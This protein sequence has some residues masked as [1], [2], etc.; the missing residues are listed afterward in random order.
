VNAA[1]ALEWHVLTGEYPPQEG[2]VA[3]YTRLVARGLADAGDRV[4]VWAPPASGSA[5]ADRGI[6][7]RRLPDCYGR[8]ALAELSGALDRAAAPHR[9]LVQYVPHAFGWRAGNLRFCAWLRSRRRDHVWV[10]FHEVAYP[11]E[12]RAGLRRH[13]LAVVN[14]VMASLV[15]GAAERAFISI[16]AWQ[17]GVDAVTRAGTPIAWLPVPSPI[18]VAGSRRDAAGLAATFGQGHPL[19]GHFGTYGGLIKPLLEPAI[20]ALAGRTDCRILL[21]GRGSGEACRS[22]VEAHP[23]LAERVRATGA[24]E[25]QD[26]SRHVSACTVMMQ[27][28]PD[29]ISSRRTSAMVAL[30]H[31]VPIASN[32]GPLSEPVW[33]ESN[34]VALAAPGDPAGLAALAASLIADPDRRDDLARRGIDLYDSQFDVRHTIAALRRPA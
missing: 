4:I 30:A 11:F 8:R 5:P 32:D 26:V 1:S 33:R 18:A 14:R 23:A 19:V 28:Y 6:D 3:D 27:P 16:P 20:V 13:A 25:P 10:M 29:G 31:G 24:L 9:V 7:V 2:G 15:G 34:A 21:I 17:P 22:I 12:R